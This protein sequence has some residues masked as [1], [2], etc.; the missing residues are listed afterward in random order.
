M[1]RN[2]LIVI[3]LM[4]LV[5]F[6]AAQPRAGPN[7]KEGSKKECEVSFKCYDKCD[8]GDEDGEGEKH[9]DCFFDCLGKRPNDKVSRAFT[10][11]VKEAFEWCKDSQRDGARDAKIL[12]CTLKKV[13]KDACRSYFRDQRD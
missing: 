10:D 6:A 2:A 9:R 4:G 13:K 1:S 8:H 3:A 7:L 11:E 12:K 5:A